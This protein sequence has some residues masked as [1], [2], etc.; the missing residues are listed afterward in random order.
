MAD[1]LNDKEYGEYFRRIEEELNAPPINNY[2]SEPR[3]EK[4]KVKRKVKLNMRPILAAVS[5]IVI[6]AII[7]GVVKVSSNKEK[8]T[9]QKPLGAGVKVDKDK[10]KEK[11]VLPKADKNTI[12]LTGQLNSKYAVVINRE[13]K[14][15]ISLQNALLGITS[16]HKNLLHTNYTI[17]ASA[18]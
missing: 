2:I 8:Y 3:P 1:F 13:N 18:S 7:L 12:D 5:L 14:K 17:I 4:I 6:I 16:W 9:I 11:V 10:S 15:I